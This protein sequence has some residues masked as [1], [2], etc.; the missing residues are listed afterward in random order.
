[1]HRRLLATLVRFVRK[2]CL[3]TAP[4]PAADAM[5]RAA[6]PAAL[7]LLAAAAHAAALPPAVRQALRAADV[8]PS[9]LSVWLQEVDTPG[10]ANARPRLQWQP[11]AARNPASL[12]KLVTTSAALDLLGPAFH[13]QTPVWLDGPVEGG[14]LHG[15]LVIRGSGD[16]TLVL[17]R[18]WLLLRRVRQLGVN[19]IDGDIVLDRS[20]FRP[21]GGAPG[22]FDG[23][24][25]KPYNVQ[26]DALL[27]NYGAVVYTFTPQPDTRTAR[28][29]ADPDLAGVSLPATVPLADGPCE[30]WRAALKGR[31]DDARQVHF[32][33][34]YPAACGERQWP[35]ASTDP[36]RYDA[37][38]IE[39][40]WRSIGGRLSGTVHDGAAPRERPPSFSMAS[41]PLAEVVRTINKFSNNV[42]AEQLFLTLAAVQSADGTASPAAARQLL[43]QWLAGRLG[44][45][46]AASAVIDNGAGLSRDGRVTARLLAALL[47]HEWNAP[48]MPELAASLPITGEDG[49]L[50]HSNAPAGCAHLK[51]GSLRD[52]AGVA[53][54]LR[55]DSGRRYVL[56]AMINDPHAPQAHEVLDALVTWACEDAP[57]A[58][59]TA[60][61][62]PTAAPRL[63]DASRRHAAASPVAR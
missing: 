23:E 51:T 46:L 40:L 13:W 37:Q 5:R 57:T 19:E 35:V 12:F 36:G 10:R 24:P 54:Y 58:L 22:D 3:R 52:A 50:E 56:V 43:Q 4:A 1:M 31:F 17:E 2:S 25:L 32:D 49:T 34:A 27:L 6:A 41:P 7:A 53:G 18:A 14:V 62:V 59:A 44:D 15:P 30:D 39:A 47:Q 20:A 21:L 38:L 61:A 29:S 45:A 63:P 60:A 11:D 55:A 8:P 16:P 42:M 33:G 9:S 28:V 26:P 48:T